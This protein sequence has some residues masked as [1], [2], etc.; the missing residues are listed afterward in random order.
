MSD[1]K[2][3]HWYNKKEELKSA[4]DA[5]KKIAEL[6]SV[7]ITGEGA[8]EASALLVLNA[9]KTRRELEAQLKALG[10]FYNGER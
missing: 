1:D 4:L 3:N 9:V 6:T 5:C 8:S 2:Y 10:D 7:F